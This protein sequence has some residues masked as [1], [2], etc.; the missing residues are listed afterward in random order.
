MKN[1]TDVDIEA[2][3]RVLFFF[4]HIIL[5]IAAAVYTALG[6]RQYA[7]LFATT[8][9]ISLIYFVIYKV[10]QVNRRLRAHLNLIEEAIQDSEEFRKGVKKQSEKDGE[11]T[12]S[13]EDILREKTIQGFKD[14]CK[15]REEEGFGE[16]FE[17]K[18]E[19]YEEVERIETNQ[20][21]REEVIAFATSKQ[22]EILKE[23]DELQ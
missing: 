23:R 13:L 7:I 5:F 3:F 10:T 1:V 20:L 21:Q 4:L 8:S 12:R 22:V 17:D 16:A 14:Y 6:N 18:L 11:V 19:F 2:D 15:E 9:L